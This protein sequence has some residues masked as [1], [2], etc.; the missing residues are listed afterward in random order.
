MAKGVVVKGVVVEGVVVEGVV[1]EAVTVEGIADATVEDEAE[2]DAMT[3]D[4]VG[5]CVTV[6]GRRWEGDGGSPTRRR[7]WIVLS[8]AV[9]KS[10]D[11]SE[12]G[13][14]LIQ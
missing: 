3:G 10:I 5:D 14:Q 7:F 11:E 12:N 13:T 8:A 4:D 9:E 6:D 1:M 2:A